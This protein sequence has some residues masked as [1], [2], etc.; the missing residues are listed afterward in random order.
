MR[1]SRVSA[2]RTAAGSLGICFVSYLVGVFALF[3]CCFV[4]GDGVSQLSSKCLEY[5]LEPPCVTL[6]LGPIISV[7]QILE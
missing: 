7:L 3:C 6:T 1:D 2:S 5:R 4:F